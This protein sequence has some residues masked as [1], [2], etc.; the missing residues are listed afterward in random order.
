MVKNNILTEDGKHVKILTDIKVDKTLKKYKMIDQR[1]VKDPLENVCQA[2]GTNPPLVEKNRSAMTYDNLKKF[3][4]DKNKDVTDFN[5]SVTEK[6]N[7][8]IKDTSLEGFVFNGRINS[9][10]VEYAEPRQ[11]T[12]WNYIKDWFN[13]KKKIEA[14][15]NEEEEEKKFDVIGFFSDLHNILD[16]EES[17]KYVNRISDI[18]EC[19]GLAELSGQIA[20]K[21][22]LIRSLVINKMESILYVKCMYKTITEDVLVQL[23]EK[24]PRAL[25]L[26]YL[27]NFTRSIPI[28]VIKKKL[29]ADNLCVFD[30]YVVLHYDPENDGTEMTDEEKEKEK[31]KK[32]DP[33]LCGLI[34]GSN[35][36]YFVSDWIDEKCDLT[37]DKLIEIVGKEAVES[38]ILTDKVNV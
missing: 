35:K 19:I 1:K 11:V 26:D 12:F 36:L 22:K 33:I 38:G 23:C 8:I 32:Q 4:E 37:Y 10:S 28:E 3:M 30:N 13:H 27:A 5:V 15:I 18:I 14:E 16:S 20:L 31:R 2:D 25:R 29:E 9:G 24:A 34:T 7:Q 21:E 6:I 17:E